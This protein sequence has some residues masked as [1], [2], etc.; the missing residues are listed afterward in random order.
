M[1]IRHFLMASAAVIAISGSALAADLPSRMAPPVY[2]PPP[3]FG[4]WTGFYAGVNV[5]YA[6]NQN[7]ETYNELFSSYTYTD[8]FKSSGFIGGGQIGY[9]YQFPSTAYVI[10]L[11]TDFQGSGVKGSF[12]E[13]EN[14]DGNYGYEYG[15]KLEWFGT[16]R[17]RVGYS[18]G[19]ILPY[20]TGGFAY[21]KVNTFDSSYGYDESSFYDSESHI[22]TGWTVGAGLEYAITHNITFKTEYLY[23]DLG[24]KGLTDSYNTDSGSYYASEKFTF[25]TVRAGLNYKFDWAAP[26][27]VVAKY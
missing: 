14:D 6:G 8:Q 5:G 7:S 25:H 24:S 11:E 22:H 16:V 2:T 27:P 18:L 4:L 20:V 12:R 3:A 13:N 21:G 23:T 17:A 1:M 10:G 19:Q 26:A 9:N 15:S